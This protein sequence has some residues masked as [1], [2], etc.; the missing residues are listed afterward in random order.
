MN[1]ELTLE[2]QQIQE[3]ARKFDE[4]EVAPLAREAD[5]TGQFPMH[6]IPRMGQLGFLAGPIG[7]EYGGTGMDYPSFALV[8]E[9]IGRAD[10]SGASTRIGCAWARTESGTS[11]TR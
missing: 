7:P 2:Q 11:R 9:E 5:E 3:Q 4:Q 6:L 8:Y 10:S 1:F